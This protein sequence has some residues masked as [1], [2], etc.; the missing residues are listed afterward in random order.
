MERC[1]RTLGERTRVDEERG[2]R[3]R[4][5]AR[6]AVWAGS[7]RLSV[8]AGGESEVRRGAGY[9]WRLVAAVP[10]G[11]SLSQ[12]E[13]ARG[14][15]VRRAGMNSWVP[16]EMMEE[17]MRGVVQLPQQ[18]RPAEHRP[19]RHR[20]D[21]TATTSPIAHDRENSSRRRRRGAAEAAH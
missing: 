3:S 2:A 15:V 8:G 5:R 4:F 7:E 19:G 10:P 16:R 11:S 6:E 18:R 9:Y 14:R 21:A 17:K 13:G 1:L 12:E 20:F